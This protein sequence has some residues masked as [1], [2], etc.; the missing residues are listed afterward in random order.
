VNRGSAADYEALARLGVDVKGKIALARYF[1][2]Y[3]GGKSLEAENGG[4]AMLVYSEPIDDGCSRRSVSRGPWG[5][6]SKV[7]RGANV[8]DFIVPAIAH[9][10]WASTRA[11]VG[12]PESESEILPKLPI[13]RSPRD[14]AEIRAVAAGR[15]GRCRRRGGALYH[16]GQGRGVARDREH[17]AR[18]A[19]SGT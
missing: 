17:R 16:V 18:R 12:S 2:G 15:A 1:G 8:Y 19:R 10:R 6:D 13:C 9:A 3:R 11:P 5:N 4:R 14:A 7:Q